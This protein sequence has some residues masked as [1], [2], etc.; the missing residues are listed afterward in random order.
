MD[1]YLPACSLL[2]LFTPA[3]SSD[4]RVQ[5]LLIGGTHRI[6]PIEK[7]RFLLKSASKVICSSIVR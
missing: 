6:V 4:F 7:K 1:H 2:F 5:L 3:L